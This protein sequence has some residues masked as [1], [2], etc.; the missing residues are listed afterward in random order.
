MAQSVSFL[1]CEL[2]SSS[3]TRTR[4]AQIAMATAIAT[5][6][7]SAGAQPDAAEVTLVSVRCE[8]DELSQ[9]EL[10]ELLRVE[11]APLRVNRLELPAGDELPE[12]EARMLWMESCSA[13]PPNFGIVEHGRVIAR[14]S[15]DL[16][17]VAGEAR[18]RALALA[19]AEYYRVHFELK[20]AA[21]NQPEQP[22]H[23]A[24]RAAP[25][26]ATPRE[27]PVPPASGPEA[28]KRS[29]LQAYAA[30]VVRDFLHDATWL[31]GP[32]AG[33]QFGRIRLGAFA[34]VN[35]SADAFGHV[36]LGSA[37]ARFSYEIVLAGRAFELGVRVRGETGATFGTGQ[38][39]G[40]AGV[41]SADRWAWQTAALLELPLRARLGAALLG[42]LAP[43]F[44]IGRGLVAH[45]DRARVAS[46]DGLLF[47]V[48]LAITGAPEPSR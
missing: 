32:E 1:S 45:R 10:V 18:S 21:A 29:K 44:G 34:L 7:S 41:K 8:E 42:E 12:R 13:K 26:G 39:S 17:D 31:A 9:I 3:R 25:T 4:C 27:V 14:E 48:A 28:A 20:A 23:P 22:P 38:A 24:S 40:G 47:G 33:V 15:I 11:L 16:S 6:A 30:A 37:C 46:T 2:R 43:S 19:L 36:I 35:R 5:A